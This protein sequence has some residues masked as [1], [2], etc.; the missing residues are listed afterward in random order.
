MAFHDIRLPQGIELGAIGGPRFSTTIIELTSGFEQRNINWAQTRGE[1]D[2]SYAIDETNFELVRAFFYARYG[3]AHSFR[4]KDWSDYE[5]DRQIMMVTDGSTS[6]VNLFKRY[7]SG[8]FN[9]DKLLTK[10]VSGSISAWV[11]NVSQTVVEDTGPAATEVRVDLLT[12]LC[13]LG[14]THAS[15][16]GYDVELA[17]EFDFPVRFVKEGLDVNMRLVTA[18]SVPNIDIIE[19]RGE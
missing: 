12:G 4:F 2:I 1:W 15:T 16:T 13:T 3:N 7:S 10:I 9:F 18:G 11:N 5:L 8:G 19:V 17:F 14:T 6:T